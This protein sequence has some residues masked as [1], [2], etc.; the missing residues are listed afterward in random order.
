MVSETVGD[1]EE[2]YHLIYAQFLEDYATST[3]KRTAAIN[4]TDTT[5]CSPDP[6]FTIH[7]VGGMLAVNVSWKSLWLSIPLLMYSQRYDGTIL[8]VYAMETEWT[9]LGF[10]TQS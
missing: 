5:P 10:Q 4:I 6:N 2:S 9:A 1:T 3:T 8:K 7:P